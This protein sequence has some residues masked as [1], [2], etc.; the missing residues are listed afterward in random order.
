MPILGTHETAAILWDHSLPKS[1]RPRENVGVII[2][3]SPEKSTISC[4]ALK[5]RRTG[6]APGHFDI[7]VDCPLQPDYAFN[8]MFLN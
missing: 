7:Y 6:T 3:H 5:S 1:G 4:V 8:G 2:G